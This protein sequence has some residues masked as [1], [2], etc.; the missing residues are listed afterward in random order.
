VLATVFERA[1]PLTAAGRAPAAG[2][3]GRPPP[4]LCCAAGSRRM[5][6]KILGFSRVAPVYIP[7]DP[8]ELDFSDRV[9]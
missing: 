4:V 5:T 3:T 1:A 6:L 2:K 9:G 7:P 8:G